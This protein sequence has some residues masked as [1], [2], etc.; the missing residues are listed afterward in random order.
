MAVHRDVDGEAVTSMRIDGDKSAKVWAKR[1]E[2]FIDAFEGD[3]AVMWIN[4][5]TRVLAIEKDGKAYDMYVRK[6]TEL[7]DE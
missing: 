7:E 6:V 2:N 4:P 3:G 5:E 1:L